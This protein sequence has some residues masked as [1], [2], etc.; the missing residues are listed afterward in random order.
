MKATFKKFVQLEELQ[1]TNLVEYEERFGVKK[2]II[3][4]S[5]L[6]RV[7][8]YLEDNDK[9]FGIVS[10]F[11]G[12]LWHP[13]DRGE[14]ESLQDELVSSGVGEDDYKSILN[15]KKKTL[16]KDR[17]SRSHKELKSKVRSLGLGF[18]ELQGGFVETD[19]DG[20]EL[21]VTEISLFIP[22]ISRKQ[23]SELGVEYE[24]DSVI[25]KDDEVF[26][27]IGTN[28]TTGVG[29]VLSNFKRGSGRANLS[30]SGEFQEFFSALLKGSHRGR[31]FLFNLDE[32]NSFLLE[33]KQPTSFNK[34]AYANEWIKLI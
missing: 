4:E 17:N 2:D 9:P 25:F 23:I 12:T 34:A 27:E 30:I 14:L 26:I 15:K 22:K 5:S 20:N 21:L 3:N 7:F 32:S 28:E 8:S 29:K 1:Q 6:S 24:Q 33:K 16:I 11:R 18:F 19:D 10:A 13:D 31:K